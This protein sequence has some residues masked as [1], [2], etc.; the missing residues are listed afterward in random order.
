MFR[1][2]GRLG[3]FLFPWQLL[4]G[5][6]SR[7]HSDTYFDETNGYLERERGREKREREVKIRYYCRR[8]GDRE[9]EGEREVR[10]GK[11]GLGKGRSQ[12]KRWSDVWQ[13]CRYEQQKLNKIHFLQASKPGKSYHIIIAASLHIV[14][15]GIAEDLQ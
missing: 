5:F 2:W 7:A 10:K 6:F 13:K 3:A 8:K 11:R 15:N 1:G 9:R 12:R 4:C 14:Y